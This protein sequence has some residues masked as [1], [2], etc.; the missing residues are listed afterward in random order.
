[1]REREHLYTPHLELDTYLL[2]SHATL[3]SDSLYARYRTAFSSL[4]RLVTISTGETSSS[5]NSLF[6]DSLCPRGNSSW[7]Y[8]GNHHTPTFLPLGRCGL[9]HTIIYRSATSYLLPQLV[10]QSSNGQLM[11]RPILERVRDCACLWSSDI[12]FKLV[13]GKQGRAHCSYHRDMV[14]YYALHAVCL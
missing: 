10:D 7:V 5:S 9:C 13:C 4:S 6:I 8:V 14:S 11:S 1:M 3:S 12:L 2:R